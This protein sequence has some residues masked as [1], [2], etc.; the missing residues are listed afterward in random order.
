MCICVCMLGVLGACK[1]NTRYLGIFLIFLVVLLILQIVAIIYQ[2]VD[3]V[4]VR[5][6]VWNIVI[7]AILLLGAIFT[8]DLRRAVYT[9]LIHKPTGY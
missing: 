2:A 3:D 5:N 8:A 7:A 6:W 4:P 9:G 1:L